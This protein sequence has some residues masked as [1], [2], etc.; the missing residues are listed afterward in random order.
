MT[1]PRR[2]APRPTRPSTATICTASGWIQADFSGD[3]PAAVVPQSGAANRGCIAIT[4]ATENGAAASFTRVLCS[5][6]PPRWTYKKSCPPN[7]PSRPWSRRSNCGTGSP[8]VIVCRDGSSNLPNNRGGEAA[9]PFWK[10]TRRAASRFALP[11]PWAVPRGLRIAI[12]RGSRP[13]V[14]PRRG[15]RWTDVEIVRNH[16]DARG[17]ELQ[18]VAELPKTGSTALGK[19]GDGCEWALGRGRGQNSM[20]GSRAGR[21]SPHQ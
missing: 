20:V 11:T 9:R 14:S 18:A 19:S 15:K 5:A 17:Y 10:S 3:V 1:M 7:G 13:L 16:N 2:S 12:A 21:R 4:E 6:T 8:Q